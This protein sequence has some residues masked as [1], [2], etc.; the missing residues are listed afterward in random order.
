MLPEINP[1]TLL[2][3]G[4]MIF[5]VFYLLSGFVNLLTLTLTMP[6]YIFFNNHD[7]NRTDNP[8][9]P[10]VSFVVEVMQG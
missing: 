3:T 5:V 10:I 4:C 9:N 2:C 8:H 6:V 1:E 7:A